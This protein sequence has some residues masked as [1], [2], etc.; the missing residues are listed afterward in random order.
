MNR[1]LLPLKEQIRSDKFLLNASDLDEARQEADAKADQV[2]EYVMEGQLK[3]YLY[4][5]FGAKSFDEVAAL[6]N[7][8]P[9]LAAFF[10]EDNE[11][12]EW[13][14]KDKLEIATEL[15]RNNGNEFLFMLGIVS[16]PYC[17]AASKGALS[18][19]HTE[20][21]R[22][23]TEARLLDTTS[24]IVDIMQKDALTQDGKG[25]L[26]IKQVRLRHALAR[27]YLQKIPEIVDLNEKPINQEDMAGTNLAFSYV[28]LREMPKI[29]VKIS[30]GIQDAYI[31]FWSVIGHLLGLKTSLLPNNIRE[32]FLLEK[33]ISKRHFSPSDEG[34]ELTKQLINHYKENIPNKATITLINPLIRHLLGREVSQIIGLRQAGSFYPADY[35]MTLLPAFKKFIFPPVQS[36]DKIADQI[37]QRKL[38][39]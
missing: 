36:F 38:A 10:L 27:Y 31:H 34:Q 1:N 21:I 11:L 39:S 20:K 16:L 19:Y 32:A 18:L 17:Y 15:F 9:I 12:P 37:E 30:T 28:A 29:G 26:V 8:A 33:K 13:A 23:N 4:A 24:F 25:Y 7:R 5:A 14:N 6:T 2:I 22:K 35:L 3:D